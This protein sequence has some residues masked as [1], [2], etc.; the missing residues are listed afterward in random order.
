MDHPRRE[1]QREGEGDAVAR[2]QPVHGRIHEALVQR[3]QRLEAR[4]LQLRLLW[5]S[6]E[7]F[8]EVLQVMR[9]D[10]L[11]VIARVAIVGHWGVV[12]GL[13]VRQ[14]GAERQTPEVGHKQQHHDH[15]V[16]KAHAPHELLVQNEVARAPGGGAGAATDVQEQVPS[17]RREPFADAPDG[18]AADLRQLHRL[19]EYTGPSDHGTLGPG[20]LTIW[21]EFLEEGV[22][23]GIHVRAHHRQLLLKRGGL[24]G[25]GANDAM[26]RSLP[27][28][29]V[30]NTKRGGP[31]GSRLEHWLP[32]RMP[33][34]RGPPEA[35]RSQQK[36]RASRS[37][38]VG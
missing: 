11:R 1:V 2:A 3:R 23:P 29:V 33:R 16:L 4:D 25:A 13:P 38:A 30:D 26:Q 19:R 24:P 7:G 18:A 17:P 28:V 8:Q 21:K 5:W 32:H 31:C 12:Q 27:A 14:V 36:C 34:G 6:V 15:L 22:E 35:V 20:K 37:G 10:G 9:V